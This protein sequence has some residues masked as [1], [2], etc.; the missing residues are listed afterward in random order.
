[1]K[2][3]PKSQGGIAGDCALAIEDFRNP[4]CRHPQPSPQFGGAHVERFQLFGEMLSWMNCCAC[5]G[6]LLVI[7]HDLDVARTLRTL[8][9][10]ETD[11][12]LIVDTDAVL[13]LSVALEGLKP[14]PWQVEVEQRSSGIE[15]VE[16]HLR[17]PSNSA[18]CLDPLAFGE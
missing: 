8:R 16:S 1:M 2:E 5:H 18:E 7:V 3:M 12:P 14:I 17:L 13:T 4:V 10:L 11:P 9:P 15:L 6:L